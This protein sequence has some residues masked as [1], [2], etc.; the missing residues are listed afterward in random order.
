MRRR[1]TLRRA[2]ALSRQD[3][4]G[5]ITRPFASPS[6]LSLQAAV[7]NVSDVQRGAAARK[8][9]NMP[10]LKAQWAAVAR[11]RYNA[12]FSFEE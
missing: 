4:E 3:K 12:R 10:F 2:A 11:S 1:Q 9:T 8:E 7:A 6:G 5:V